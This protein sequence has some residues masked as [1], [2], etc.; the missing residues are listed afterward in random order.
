MRNNS[1]DASGKGYP[2]SI[3]AVEVKVVDNSNSSN[4]S[5]QFQI[6]GK[7]MAFVKHM[8]PTLDWSALVQVRVPEIFKAC[9][10]FLYCRVPQRRGII[11]VLRMIRCF[12]CASGCITGG[13]VN[14]TSNMD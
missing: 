5:N 7:E 10:R 8:L 11:P 4:N 1:K 13:S 12:S 3:T 2:L 6:G 14:A 9:R